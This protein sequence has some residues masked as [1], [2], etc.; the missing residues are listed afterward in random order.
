MVAALCDLAGDIVFDA[1]IFARAP[2]GLKSIANRVDFA[3]SGDRSTCFPGH[4]GR[5]S[6][7]RAVVSWQQ[8]VGPT[9][10]LSAAYCNC[11]AV[12]EARHGSTKIHHETFSPRRARLPRPRA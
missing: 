8:A 9:V 6:C 4:N 11:R 7:E 12:L 10:Y 2:L 1:G 5:V 3:K